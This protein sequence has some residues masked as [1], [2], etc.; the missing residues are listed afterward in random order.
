VL[1]LVLLLEG[2]CWCCQKELTLLEK[3]AGF[4]PTNRAGKQV[5]NLAPF[6]FFHFHFFF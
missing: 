6:S 2:V 4:M 1:V 3:G 5:S